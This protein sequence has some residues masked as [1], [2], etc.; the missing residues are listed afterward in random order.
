MLLA[1]FEETFGGNVE[2]HFRMGVSFS[3]RSVKLFTEFYSSDVIL[4]SPLALRTYVAGVGARSTDR[5][6]D[7]DEH[8]TEQKRCSFPRFLSSSHAY[9]PQFYI[10]VSQFR[11]RIS[12][13]GDF[14]A[15]FGRPAHAYLV[16]TRKYL[17]ISL[18]GSR[19]FLFLGF[20]FETYLQGMPGKRERVHRIL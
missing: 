16:Q 10:I 7:Q 5:R 2:D 12:S 8:S 1:D 15:M 9:C 11:A 20:I 19:S 17:A 4:I 13:A 6:A 14:A 3:S 18:Q